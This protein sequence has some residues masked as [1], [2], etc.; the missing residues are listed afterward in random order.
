MM[1]ARLWFVKLGGE[2]TARSSRSA[3]YYGHQIDVSDAK[4]GAQ[5]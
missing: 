4:A 5:G 3:S 2:F 1:R